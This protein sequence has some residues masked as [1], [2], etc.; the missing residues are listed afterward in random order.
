MA[1]ILNLT[2]LPTINLD[3]DGVN[4]G[5]YDILVAGAQADNYSVNYH[6][7]KLNVEK[8]C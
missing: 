5:E 1:T 8:Q 6:N 4:V 3:G 7:G 2:T